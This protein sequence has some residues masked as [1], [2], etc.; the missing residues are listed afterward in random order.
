MY[1]AKV[2]FL[3]RWRIQTQI[4]PWGWGNGY[5]WNNTFVMLNPP[6]FHDC[7]MLKGAVAMAVNC[8]CF[9]QFGFTVFY[10]FF[11]GELE[12]AKTEYAKVKEELD[13]TMQ[14]LNEM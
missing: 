2:E 11:A 14:E 13:S 9:T 4:L 5:F 6:L 7:I 12:K 3:E 1:E 8:W 10:C